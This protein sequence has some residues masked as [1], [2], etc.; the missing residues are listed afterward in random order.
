M[1]IGIT[2]S[3]GNKILQWPA[4]S[5]TEGDASANQVGGKKQFRFVFTL[6]DDPETAQNAG[7]RLRYIKPARSFTTCD[8]ILMRFLADSALYALPVIDSTG[9]PVALLDRKEYIEFFS[10]IY[11]REIFGRRC[12]L[13]LL[14]HEDYRRNEPVLVEA[15]CS[16][17]EVAQ[18]ILDRG[19]QHM[20]TGFL[21]TREGRYAGIS[22][23]HDLLRV[24]TQR[25][26]DELVRFNAE[27]EK[28]VA[29]RTVELEA[30]NRQLESF[31]YTIAHDLRAP[32]R[33]MNGFSEMVLKVEED[34]L[35]PKSVEYLKRV[36]A[37]SRRMGELIDD[38]LNLARL[39]RQ[40]MCRR[41]INISKMAG[42]VLLA[43]TDQY[44]QRRVEIRLQP[45][46]AA[47]GDYGLMRVVLENIIGNAWKYT[48]KTEDACIEIGTRRCDEKACVFV[49]DNG[50]GFDMRY[51][52]KLFIPFQRLHHADEFEGTGIGLATV[53]KIIER[54][55]GTVAIDS[56]PSLGTTLCF[57][58]GAPA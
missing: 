7:Q 53:K 14:A 5:P 2:G 15:G 25:K 31:S 6:E 34:N 1:D 36:V 17:E 11:T 9:R 19:M 22:N 26:Q 48:A 8:S 37:G 30:A 35:S 24:I 12:I 21:V 28:R 33:A 42:E 50:A 38:L 47:N 46:I 43:L 39:S 49:R 45:G 56:A 41:E 29:A 3:V 54:H 23:G 16:I 18:I 58:L 44:P 55:G 52:Q 10:K 27:L 57:S 4:A 32:V 40:E 51:A 13:D 20:V